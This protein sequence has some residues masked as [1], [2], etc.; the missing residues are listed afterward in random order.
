[1]IKEVINN[2]RRCG[3]KLSWPSVRYYSVIFGEN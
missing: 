3:R 2:W 1:M